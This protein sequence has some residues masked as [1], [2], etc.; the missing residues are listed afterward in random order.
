[1]TAAPAGAHWRTRHLPPLLVVSGVVMLGAA[2]VGWL[3]AGPPGAA[4]AGAGVALVTAGYVLS[5]VAIAWADSVAPALVLPVGLMTYVVKLTV[6]AGVL[7]VAAELGWQ[8][9]VPAAWGVVAGVLGWTAAQIWWLAG[10]TKS[11]AGASPVESDSRPRSG[12]QPAVG[13]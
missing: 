4:G 2:A 5:T 3:A 1:M 6:I 9:L 8:G 12:Q 10:R 11:G 7:V 13:E